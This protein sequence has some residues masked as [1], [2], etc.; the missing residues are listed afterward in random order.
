MSQF[1]RCPHS[2]LDNKN[3]TVD[4]HTRNRK[5]RGSIPQGTDQTTRCLPNILLL[6]LVQSTNFLNS[7]LSFP[8]ITSNIFSHLS[9]SDFYFLLSST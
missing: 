6:I 8:L 2:H 5:V 4:L 1:I 3:S 7:R 9:Y